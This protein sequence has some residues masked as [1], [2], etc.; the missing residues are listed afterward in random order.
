MD[1]YLEKKSRLLSMVLRHQPDKINIVLD[2]SG[3]TDVKTLLANTDLNMAQLEE[4]VATN[5]KKRFEFND[6]KTRIRA[7]QGH[8]VKVNLGY[9]PVAPPEFLYHGTATRFLDPIMKN[10][11]K[12]MNRHQ[13][14][15]SQDLQ[16]ASSVGKRH[17]KLIILC[18]FAKRMVQ[19]LGA[20]FYVTDNQVW[21]T[22]EVPPKYLEISGDQCQ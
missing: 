16:T 10:G 13:V 17:G 9:E 20:K 18:V 8:S 14:H 5:N 15:L 11:L 1:R 4:V 7:R 19:E 3:W 6:N 12:P 2:A 21:L 22:D